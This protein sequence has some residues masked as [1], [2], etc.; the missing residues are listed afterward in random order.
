MTA[1]CKDCP[2]RRAGCHAACPRY[3]E[4]RAAC[5][6]RRAKRALSFAVKDYKADEGKKI[7]RYSRKRK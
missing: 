6:E 5:D 2:D 3:R 4:F 7:A 1:P